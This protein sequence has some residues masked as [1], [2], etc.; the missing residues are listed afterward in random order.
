LGGELHEEID[1]SEV[2]FQR[3]RG[4]ALK[5]FPEVVRIVEFHVPCDGA[6]QEYLTERSPGDQ[7]DAE[8]FTQCELRF[9]RFAHP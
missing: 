3:F 4:E 7:A 8:L 6:R 9:F 5:V 1:N 2:G